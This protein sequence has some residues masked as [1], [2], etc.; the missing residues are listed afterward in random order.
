MSNKF[1]NIPDNVPS[2][3]YP[4]YLSKRYKDI[5]GNNL[6]LLFPK[7]ISEKVQ[8]LKLFDSTELKGYCA[9]KVSAREYFISKI[10]EGDE[11][12]KPVYGVWDNFDSIDFSVLP[13]KFILKLNHG[14]GFNSFIVNKDKLLNNLPQFYSLRDRIN[15][16]YNTRYYLN[17]LELHYKYIK[18]KVFAEEIIGGDNSPLF[19]DWMVYCFNGEP[20]FCNYILHLKDGFDYSYI[21]NE[22]FER[23]DFSI[24]SSIGR[25][26]LV[27]PYNYEKMFEFARLLSK[28]FKFV[29]VDFIELDKK[30]YF[31]ELTFTPYSGYFRFNGVE[32]TTKESLKIDKMLGDMLKL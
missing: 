4:Y 27:K 19:N 6:N 17:S 15:L 13:Q 21:Y 2:F 26:N 1:E 31:A 3:L 8:W 24:M 10:S 7:L 9:D 11:Y 14:C 25:N 29:R 20:K 28:D 32:Q 18:P 12:L 5:T 30:L 16:F 22:K 23:L